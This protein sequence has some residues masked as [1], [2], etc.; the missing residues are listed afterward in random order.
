MNLKSGLAL[1]AVSL[2]WISC[3]DPVAKVN[4]KAIQAEDLEKIV[5]VRVQQYEAQGYALSDEEMQDIRQ[6]LLD[7]LVDQTLLLQQARSSKIKLEDGRVDEQYQTFLAQFATEEEAVSFLEEQG[8]SVKM[9]KDDIEVD[10]LVQKFLENE[11]FPK[12]DPEASEVQAFYDDN[13]DYFNVP[14]SIHARHILIKVS[15]EEGEGHSR[16]DALERIRNIETQL[17]EGEDFAELAKVL[18]EG[19][20]GAE[21]GDLGWF[22]RGQMVPPFEEAA[23]ALS[24]GA[25]SPIVETNFGFHLIKM[26]GRKEASVTPLEEVEESIIEFLR[27]DKLPALYD[28]YMADLKSNADIEYFSSEEENVS[29]G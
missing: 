5:S 10:L 19:P 11:L 27:Q 15:E 25:I 4:G 2:L 8:Y 13:P 12:A 7:G 29:N 24:D 22:S 16:E 14:E 17:A 6:E 9:L 1:L 3:G 28:E 20:S 21:G 23:F 26:E 18:S